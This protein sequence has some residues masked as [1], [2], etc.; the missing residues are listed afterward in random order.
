MTRIV[1]IQ[2]T[3]LTPAN[4]ALA[5]ADRTTDRVVLVETQPHIARGRLHGH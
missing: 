5:V 1:W 2:G 3:Q 4:S